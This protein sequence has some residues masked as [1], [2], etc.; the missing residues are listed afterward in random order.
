MVSSWREICISKDRFKVQTEINYDLPFWF[1]MSWIIISHLLL[2]KI[3]FL[4]TLF[5]CIISLFS[6]KKLTI[7]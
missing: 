3:V 2:F 1:T 6:K 7:S 4:K 5:L